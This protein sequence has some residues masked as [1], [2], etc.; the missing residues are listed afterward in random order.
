VP[1]EADARLL[2]SESHEF[3]QVSGSSWLGRQDRG[4]DH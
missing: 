1:T 3:L 2:G 4:P